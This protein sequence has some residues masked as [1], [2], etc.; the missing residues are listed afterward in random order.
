MYY[1]C[2]EIVTILRYY[3]FWKKFL[4]LEHPSIRI[5]EWTYY[6]GQ[7]KAQMVYEHVILKLEYRRIT[8]DVIHDADKAYSYCCKTTLPAWTQETHSVE[9]HEE[10][11]SMMYPVLHPPNNYHKA[12]N[13]IIL[14]Y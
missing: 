4:L 11:T 7:T 1:W 6:G 3:W 14:S 5:I 8:Q 10:C 12:I 2:V 13:F 9:H